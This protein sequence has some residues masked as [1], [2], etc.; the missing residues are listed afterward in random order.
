[1]ATIEILAY[2]VKNMKDFIA[3]SFD[4]KRDANGEFETDDQGRKITGVLR[5]LQGRE[6]PEAHFF[7]TSG[8]D[9][10]PLNL[11]VAMVQRI[12]GYDVP[13][14]RRIPGFEEMVTSDGLLGIATEFNPLGALLATIESDPDLDARFAQG[15]DGVR[16]LLEPLSR[17]ERRDLLATLRGDIGTDQQGVFDQARTQFSV[18]L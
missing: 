15:R 5:W 8:D 10:D 14:M 13:W 3:Y 4:G 11:F 6:V 9:K 2:R 17:D 12:E 1:M 18:S 7:H 16:R